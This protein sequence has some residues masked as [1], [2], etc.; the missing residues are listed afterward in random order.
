MESQ[1]SKVSVVICL[2]QKFESNQKSILCHWV[3]NL[4]SGM[5]LLIVSTWKGHECTV[6]GETSSNSHME[7]H[8][9]QERGL[10][11]RQ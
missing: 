8:Q 7:T 3:P 6:T 10:H 1:M 4:G 9:E 2:A 11:E 5:T